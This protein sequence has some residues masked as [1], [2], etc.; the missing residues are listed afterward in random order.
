MIVA[1]SGCTDSSGTQSSTP[2]YK[3]D[4]QVG[5]ASYD[6]YSDGSVSGGCDVVN[7]GQVTY[8]K[9]KIELD[10]YDKD[11]NLV[12]NKTKTIGQIKPGEEI[13]FFEVTTK[14]IPKGESASASV[15]NAMTS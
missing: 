13:G 9:V 1:S 11:G 6:I 14:S 10:I 5:A 15:I 8:K 4:I 2:A 3:N 7:N 12:G